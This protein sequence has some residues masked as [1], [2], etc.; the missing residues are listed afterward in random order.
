MTLALHTYEEK[1]E[2]VKYDILPDGSRVQ[3]EGFG[4]ESKFENEQAKIDAVG[5]EENLA[6][7]DDHI[8]N[9]RT[10]LREI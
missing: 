6:A 7:T 10:Q 1:E 9:V 2:Q 5:G 8:Q 4:V 3:I